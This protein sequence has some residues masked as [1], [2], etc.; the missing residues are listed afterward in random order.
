MTTINDVARLAEVSNATV[1]HVI[2]KTRKVNPETIEKVEWAI[3]ELNYQ[4]NE[5]ARGLKTGQSR[6]IGVM[7]FYSIDAYFSE[8]L[9]N[10]E[11]RAYAAGYNVLLRH[12]ADFGEE[13]G[14]AIS[15]WRNKNLDGLIINSPYV[16]PDFYDQIVQLGCPCVILH[17]HDPACPCDIIR[18]NDLE[19]TDE[20]TRYLI[21]LGHQ[22]IACIAGCAMEYQTASQRRTGYEKALQQAGIPFREDYFRCSEYSIRESYNLARAMLGQPKSPT[23]ILTYSDL[24]A[25]GVIRAAT[26]LGLSIPGDISIIGYDDIELASFSVPRLTTIYQDKKQIG[27]LAVSQIL[28]HIQDP[29][30]PSEEIV[31]SSRLVIRESTGPAKNR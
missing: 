16:T 10:L 26:D 31:L 30:L 24:L 17:I 7:N 23:A 21:E 18:S 5:Q 27:E 8:V 20:A 6:L 13:Q 14:A 4:P 15:S 2:N 11:A 1:S 9:S 25:I 19:V 12:T 28:K 22:R 29:D 3:R